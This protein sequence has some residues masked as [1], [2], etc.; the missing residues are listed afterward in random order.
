MENLNKL[1]HVLVGS[2][3]HP[4]H[5]WSYE[6]EC[7]PQ[8]WP[9]NF[10][11]ARGRHQSPINIE[12]DRCEYDSS[13]IERPL[14]ID[15]D[16]HSCSQIKNTGYTF[17][18]DSYTTNLSTVSGGPVDHQYSF[19]QFH[20][21]WGDSLQRGSEHLLDGKAYSAEL[22]FVNWNHQSYKNPKAATSSNKNDGLL[23][24]GVF[25]KIGKH[26]SEF[27]KIV[28]LLH[29]IHLKDHHVPVHNINMLK[30]MP[31]NTNDYWTYPGSLTT[32][33]CN[34][35][36]QWI[37]FKDPIEISEGQLDKCHHLYCVSQEKLCNEKT[38]IKYNDR[39]VCSMGDRIVRKSFPN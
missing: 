3:H 4:R 17:Q 38:T 25:I 6:G 12:T 5:E 24:L 14:T 15:Y 2:V 11:G 21:H 37:L 27:E 26:N 10:V 33:P 34:E 18:V 30:L 16:H 1:V 20:M 8:T 22:H 31:E 32:P 19:L 36:V 29:D 7:G 28:N 35:C 13:L 9:K 39:P 23:V